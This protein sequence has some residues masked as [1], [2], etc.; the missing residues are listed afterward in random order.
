[1]NIVDEGIKNPAKYGPCPKLT[2]AKLREALA[3]ALKKIDAN[4]D[5]FYDKFPSHASKNN[6]YEAV[7]NV[8]GWNQGFWSGILWLAYEL[9]GDEKYRKV[10]E[11]QI[12]SYTKRITEKLG[13]NHHDMGF[14]FI[15]SCV[16]AYKLTGNEEA[17]KTAIMAADHLITRYHEKGK[18]IQAWGNVDDKSSRR[19]IIDCL[20]NIPL[21]YW[22]SEVTGDNKYYEMAYNHFLATTNNIIRED[23]STYHTFYFD[24]ET[25]A[26]EKGVTAQGYSDDSCWSRGQAWGLYG[27][28]LTYI[29]KKDPKIIDTFKKI[30]NYFLNRLPED[31][32]AY[33]DLI[34]TDGDEERDSSASAIAVCGILEALKW[35]DESDPLKEIYSNAAKHIILSLYETY[36]TKDTPESNGLLLHAV[37]GKPQGNGVDE[38]NIWGDYYYMEALARMLMDWKLYS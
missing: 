11:A 24:P 19:L 26:P 6:V 28:M 4:L 35:M 17:K 23:S 9:T 16:A 36:S 13:V 12:P 29:Y 27:H 25:G 2:E 34:F 7:E 38:C 5:V 30:T 15:P 3:E 1:M 10:A 22:A 31:Y 18:F 14:L 37:Y 21:L 8:G 33:W 32:V 20:M